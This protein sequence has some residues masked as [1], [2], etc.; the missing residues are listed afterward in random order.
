MKTLFAASKPAKFQAASSPIGDT[1]LTGEFEIVAYTGEAMTL[2]GVKHP[3]VIDLGSVSTPSKPRP[4]LRDHETSRIAGHTSGFSF[5]EN[6]VLVSAR[7]SADNEESSEILRSARN[8]FPW[9]ASLG[10]DG[11]LVLTKS[12]D[13]VEVNGRTFNGPV[14]VCYDTEIAEVSFV[15]LGADDNTS[16]RLVAERILGKAFMNFSEW[17]KSKGFNEAD[18][19][20]DQLET[21][22]AAY[23]A[24][25]V[26]DDVAG[27]DE[28]TDDAAGT[29]SDEAGEGDEDSPV[30]Q[31]RAE[32]VRILGVSRVASRHPEIEERAVSE[33]W[34]VDQTRR[35]VLRASRHAPRRRTSHTTSVDATSLYTAAL[36]EQRNLSC[37]ELSDQCRQAAR[38]RFRGR[39]SIQQLLLTAARA[40]GLR[41]DSF[42]AAPREIL[43]AAFSTSEVADA[44]SNVANK[45]ILRGFE[46]GESTWRAVSTQSNVSDFKQVE[47]Y[48]LIGDDEYEQVG[49]EG[50][51]AHGSLDDEKYTNQADMFGKLFTINRK[52]LIN[53]DL[54]VFDRLRDKLGR[55]AIKKLNK[56]FWTEFL[57]GVTTFFH[58][59][60]GNVGTTAFSVDGL[61]DAVTLFDNQT[62][63]DGDPLALEPAI[64]LVPN[65]LKID[66]QTTVASM[67]IQAA[68]G[69]VFKN[70]HSGQFRV[71]A[72]SYLN[73]S[74]VP[75]G[76]A[77]H[78][79][80]L[81]DPM[82]LAMIDVCFLDGRQVP[83]I[84]SADAAFN[85][86]GIQ[87]RGVFDFGVRKQ[88]YRAA[89]RMT[90]AG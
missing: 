66:A 51:I 39:L 84:E 38:D 72:S 52:D 6:S 59:D 82:D 27:D 88:E 77:A 7:L 73:A 57:N 70:P 12:G 76:S 89:V 85:T 67:E 55:G 80:L 65:A 35:E 47:S 63:P 60:R 86:L 20:E 24:E 1:P 41:V 36:C 74:T 45:S 19:T 14:Y 18:L 50:N 33:G 8:G 78:Y 15:A 71:E 3:V 44:L 34:S 40:N 13:S 10:F 90:G 49:K 42:W 16:A 58:A 68:E 81:A 48:R 43:R 64:L 83:T 46:T 23:A 53:D 61:T 56:V 54:G 75:N 29:P 79:F 32:R 9:Q 25:H 21:L 31:M 11:R 2:P 30:D 28:D 26:S 22:Q 69:G 5:S 87:M 37:D 62:D 4:V 17:L